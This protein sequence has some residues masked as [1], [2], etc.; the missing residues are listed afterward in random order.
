MHDLCLFFI[1]WSC[2]NAVSQRYVN[3]KGINISKAAF[4]ITEYS[5]TLAL[6][7]CYYTLISNL[8]TLMR[9][10]NFPDVIHND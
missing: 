7:Y 4:E 9:N 2:E 5:Y 8:I 6:V 10:I 3:A 1:I